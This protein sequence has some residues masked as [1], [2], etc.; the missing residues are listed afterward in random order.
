MLLLTF[1]ST[2]QW[3][4]PL[5]NHFTHFSESASGTQQIN[6]FSATCTFFEI[7]FLRESFWILVSEKELIIYENFFSCSFT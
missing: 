7:S 4:L 1:Q 6:I 3:E 2:T 5:E